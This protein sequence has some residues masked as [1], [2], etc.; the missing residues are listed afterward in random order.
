M[1]MGHCKHGEFELMK[2]CP[3]CIQEAREVEAL[4]ETVPEPELAI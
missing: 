1:T 3:D 2:G 4:E